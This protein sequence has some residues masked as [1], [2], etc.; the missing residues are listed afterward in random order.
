MGIGK[1]EERGR[2]TAEFKTVLDGYL[3]WCREN[4]TEP[5]AIRATDISMAQ[6]NALCHM[7]LAN[8]P[9]DLEQDAPITA[10]EAAEIFMRILEYMAE[11][12]GIDR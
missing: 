1:S 9:P 6:A 11:S 7:F 10:T 5:C 12:T 4:R 8:H 3:Q 2:M